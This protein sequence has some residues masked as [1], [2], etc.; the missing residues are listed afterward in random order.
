MAHTKLEG[1]CLG[2]I[3]LSDEGYDKG[4]RKLVDNFF[5]GARPV[6]CPAERAW[7]PPTDIF[8]TC[9]AIHIKVEL[10]GVHEEDVEVKVSNNF[11]V[12][13]G[14]RK[15]EQQAKKENFHLMEIQYGTFERIFG[16]PPHMDLKE[17]SASL[18]NG[19]LMVTIP[20]DT[21][22]REYRIQID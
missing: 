16:M 2:E 19:F 6:F 14:R 7:N 21:K 4:F 8:E 18:K 13:R 5:E 3:S 22:L 1:A 10:A 15:D 11:V 12:I 20:K 17:V 9:N